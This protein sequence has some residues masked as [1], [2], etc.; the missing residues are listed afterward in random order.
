MHQ[1]RGKIWREVKRPF[2]PMVGV[3]ATSV[4]DIKLQIETHD[5]VS[6]DIFDTLL[7]RPYV[8]PR[9]LFLHLE[10]IENASNFARDRVLAERMCRES[11]EDT[12]DISLDDIY[13]TVRPCFQ[14]MKTKEL[15]LE[16]QVL[17]I[18][19]EIKELFD[20]AVLLHK[21]IVIVSDMYLSA[22]FLEEVLQSKGF[23]GYEKL[24][25]SS[26][27][28]LSKAT[29]NLYKHVIGE[30]A[31]NADQ[32]LHIGDNYH[33]DY[34]Q[35]R[36]HGISAIVVPKIIDRLFESNPRIEKYYSESFASI[37]TSM[38]IGLA[39]FSVFCQNNNYWYRLGFSFAG[40]IVL[41]YVKWLDREFTREGITDA[42][43]IARDG[44]SLQ[45]AFEILKTSKIRS[46][47]V[48]A[49]RYL[50]L[51]VNLNYEAKG[52]KDANWGHDA[53]QAIVDYYRKDS[54]IICEE[55]PLQFK[56]KEAS[57]RFIKK[58]WHTF[59][60][61]ADKKKQRY[62]QYIGSLQ[63]E[64]SVAVVD[65]S[66]CWFTSQ[67]LIASVC[68][69]SKNVLGYY[70][71]TAPASQKALAYDFR[72]FHRDYTDP[73]ADWRLLELFLTA[74]HPPIIDVSGDK[75]IYDNT[76][77]VE[78]DRVEAYK[79]ILDGIL[80][81]IRLAKECF[82]SLDCCLNSHDAANWCNLITRYPSDEDARYL[83]KIKHRMGVTHQQQF[84]LQLGKPDITKIKLGKLTVLTRHSDLFGSCYYL[85]KRLP[86]WR[87]CKSAKINRHY[88][89]GIIPMATIQKHY[90]N[91]KRKF[92]LLGISF[93]STKKQ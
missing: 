92:S 82:S 40:P 64:N 34:V 88:L 85:F 53:R 71:F 56:T 31:I 8:K 36:K 37:G 89:L 67:G 13:E 39:A 24:Y 51:I 4:S 69:N 29:G 73:F 61:L 19:P 45:K 77:K 32:M 46:H 9:D 14:N 44:Y 68:G 25:V 47:Y 63:T 27:M 26:E 30:L 84:S 80:D 18:N 12:E 49:P 6:F 57:E 21:R 43:F 50:D 17:Q 38:I 42:F 10:K 11:L 91:Q 81:F 65:S 52:K 54:E 28:K 75:P 5:V 60:T 59:Q 62:M 55:A 2:T 83:S 74:P 70:Y 35:A 7:V 1:R 58:H 48:Y 16:K 87:V 22:D 90:T 72:S 41:A 33:S 79:E 66:T 20:Y 76:T 86:L 78:E 23:Q 93:T 15:A 3:K